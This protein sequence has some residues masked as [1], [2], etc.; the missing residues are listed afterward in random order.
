MKIL[1]SWCIALAMYS[2]IPVPQFEWKEEDMRYALCFFPF[3]G[4]IIAGVFLL[5]RQGAESFG[6]GNLSK[7]FLTAAIPIF[8][9]GG[10]HIDGYM[11]TMDAFHSYQ[12]KEKKLEILKDP[13]IGAFSVIMLFLYFFLYLAVLSEIKGERQTQIIAIGFVLSRILSAAGVVS[14]KPSKKTGLLKIFADAASKRN[15]KIVL[16]IEGGICIAWMWYLSPLTTVWIVGSLIF[17]V[18]YYR[19]KCYK[20]FGGVSGDTAGYFITMCEGIIAAVTVIVR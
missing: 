11:D 6:I 14:F 13:H 3:V 20:E 16:G 19:N 2:K 17:W 4:V 12:D 15:V 5:F 7:T 1:K 18:C 8:I 10:I 9:T